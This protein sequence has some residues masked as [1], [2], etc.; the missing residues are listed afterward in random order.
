MTDILQSS[1]E[2]MLADIK[3]YKEERG[4]LSTIKPKN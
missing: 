3:R 4:G 2:A 1:L